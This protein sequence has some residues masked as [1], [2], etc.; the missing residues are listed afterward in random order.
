MVAQAS[1]VSFAYARVWESEPHVVLAEKLTRL[2][3]PG[4]DAA[5]FVS[6]GSE[7]MEAAIKLARQWA[8]ARGQRDRWKVISRMPSYHG[9]T[10]AMMGISG[11]RE[12]ARPFLPLLVDMPKVPAPFTYRIPA[13]LGIE[14]YAVNCADELDRRIEQEGA[15]SV[16]AFVMEP[17]GGTATGA[18]VAHPTYYSRVREVCSRHGV[19][20]VFD[21]VMSGAGRTGR[22]LAAHHWADCQPDI[23]ALAK[24]VSGGYSPLGAVLCSTDMVMDVR[25]D[26]GFIHGHTYA[27]N[28]L[29]CAVGCAVLDELVEGRLI[30]NADVRG[31][32]LRSRL[33]ALSG[34][35][36]LIGDVRGLGLLNAIEIVQDPISK[37]AFSA[38]ADAI[39]RIR[40][41]CAEEGLMLLSRRTSGGKFGEWLMVCPPLTIDAQQVDDLVGRLENALSR[42]RIEMA[43]KRTARA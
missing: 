43:Q 33:R 14:Q 2:A 31:D 32:Q 16:L 41:L 9:S 28:P 5:F 30:D 34:H 42:F 17:V 29:S 13:G 39:G 4:L 22:F 1:K 38:E 23:V 6:G 18:L 26:G 19:L 12:F 25:R 35:C 8:C 36:E 24:G 15:E 10:I 20:L 3:G 7:A 27:A 40:E 21:E 37:A 11:D